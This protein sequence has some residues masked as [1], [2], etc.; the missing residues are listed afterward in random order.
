MNGFF[1]GLRPEH[2]SYMPFLSKGGIVMKEEEVRHEKGQK[3]LREI[4][5]KFIV[6]A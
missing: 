2:I 4:Y 5:L 6:V 1:S 3:A